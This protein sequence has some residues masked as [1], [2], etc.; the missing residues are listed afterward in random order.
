MA[1]DFREITQ[2]K[3]LLEVLSTLSEEY[4]FDAETEAELGLQ[5]IAAQLD[6]MEQRHLER[7]AMQAGRVAE[8]QVA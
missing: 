6:Q 1:R 3:T 7:E 8:R 4:E 5:A 2:N